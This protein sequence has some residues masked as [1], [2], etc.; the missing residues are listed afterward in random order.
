MSLYSASRV[1]SID[2][3]QNRG[4]YLGRHMDNLVDSTAKLCHGD[5]EAGRAF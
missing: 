3:S 1:V 5:R 2:K 4:W